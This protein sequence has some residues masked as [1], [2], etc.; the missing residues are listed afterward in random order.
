M[1]RVAKLAMASR[2]GR[3]ISANIGSGTSKQQNRNGPPTAI[4]G[5]EN[6]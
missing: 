5:R 3:L 2:S 6:N 1:N 4:G